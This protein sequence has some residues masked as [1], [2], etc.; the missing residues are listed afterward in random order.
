MFIT[1]L[2]GISANKDN[3]SRL[4]VLTQLA[5]VEIARPN[6]VIRVRTRDLTVVCEFNFSGLP[7]HLR[8]KKQ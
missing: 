4:E 8:Q 1:F 5:N 2:C 7:I 3:E 6:V